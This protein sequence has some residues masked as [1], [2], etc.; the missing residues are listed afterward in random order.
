MKVKATIIGLLA[1]SSLVACQA[2]QEGGQGMNYE[3]V[4][5]T[6]YERNVDDQTYQDGNRA[7][8]Y[9][10]DRG[11]VHN[12]NYH[13]ADEAANRIDR[14]DGIKRSYVITNRDNAYVAAILDNGE[15]SGEVPNKMERKVEKAVKAV[16]QDIQNVYVTT[17]PDFVDLSNN[18]IKDVKNGDPVQGFFKEFG[19]MVDRVFPDASQR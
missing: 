13:V 9:D 19:K 16:D 14:I 11:M 5:N 18:Y 4:Q 6:T 12:T 1:A 3:G 8:R 10:K 17:N 15:Q 2:E 7:N